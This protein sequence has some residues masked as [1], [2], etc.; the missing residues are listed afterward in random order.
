MSCTAISPRLRRCA[1]ARPHSAAPCLLPPPLPG[2]ILLEI[3]HNE[4]AWLGCSPIHILNKV[5]AG[6]APF[7]VPAAAPAPLAGLMRCCTARD[8]AQRPSFDEIL[9]V[10]Y[11]FCQSLPRPASPPAGVPL[12]AYAAGGAPVGAPGGAGGAQPSRSAP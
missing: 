11:D 3:W 9:S 2:I 5:C 12:S 6:E 8:P 1:C 10:L 4:R 7:E